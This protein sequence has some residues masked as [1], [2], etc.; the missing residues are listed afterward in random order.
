MV[1]ELYF[2]KDVKKETS[3]FKPTTHLFGAWIYNLSRP[4]MGQFTY[5]PLGVSK[6]GAGIIRRLLY[7]H[8]CFGGWCWLLAETPGR[9]VSW[10]TYTLHVAWDASLH[11]GWVPQA[12]IP[13][14][15]GTTEKLSFL[16]M[17]YFWH[18]H[19]V[20]LTT[21]Y[22]LQVSNWGQP[23]L[24]KRLIRFHLLWEEGQII[25]RLALKLS[26]SL[27]LT[28]ARSLYRQETILW[29]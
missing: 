5:A 23:V 22:V 2:N 4:P 9:I 28:L 12:S 26:H 29:V 24:K 21:F 18:S 16:F 14:R 1:Y 7:S 19:I 10:N 8:V 6:A 3:C 27:C 25:W 13:K 20:T 11:G 15:G 17:P